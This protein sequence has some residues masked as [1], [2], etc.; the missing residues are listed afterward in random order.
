MQKNG[1]SSNTTMTQFGIKV[2]IFLWIV[3]FVAVMVL[4]VVAYDKDH[5]FLMTALPIA[6]AIPCAINVNKNM[7]KL[8]AA[9]EEEKI[10]ISRRK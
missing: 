2:K 8:S 3:L 1:G 4:S 5:K 6:T 9:K 10:Y 7:K